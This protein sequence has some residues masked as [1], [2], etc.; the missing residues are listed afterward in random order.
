MTNPVDLPE[1]IHDETSQRFKLQ[2]EGKMAVLDYTVRNGVMVFTHTEV[3]QELEG[4]GL[5]G[6]LAR[7]GLEYAIQK[8]YKILPLCSFVAGY[9]QRHPEYEEWVVKR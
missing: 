3:P 1:I 6:R 2:I 8:K 9:I 7:A 4:R 5:A